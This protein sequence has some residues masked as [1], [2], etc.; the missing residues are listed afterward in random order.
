MKTYGIDLRNKVLAKKVGSKM[1]QSQRL[2]YSPVSSHILSVQAIPL[3]RLMLELRQ[4]QHNGVL[5]MLWANFGNAVESL[6]ANRMRSLLTSLGIIIGVAAV[7]GSLTLSQ[8]VNT[9]LANM[10]SSLGANTILIYPA[11]ARNGGVVQSTLVSTLTPRDAQDLQSVP[12]VVALSPFITTSDEVA[13]SNQNWNTQINGVSASYQQIGGWNLVEGTWF[14]AD[15]DARGNAVV[16]IGDTILQNL[17]DASGKDPLGQKIL[18]RNQVFRVVGVLAS[19]GQMLGG[20]PDD[21]VFIPFKTARIRLKNTTSLDQ[22]QVMVD[23]TNNVQQTQDAIARLLRG[24]HHI[25]RADGTTDDFNVFSFLQLLQQAQ[26]AI[27]I[28]AFVLIG[29]AVIA[30]VAG[31]I[32]IMNIMLVAVTERTREIGIRRALGARRGD[33]RNQFLIEA[34]VLC[35]VGGL[36]GLLLG[37]LLGRGLTQIPGATLPFVVTPITMIVPFVVSSAVAISFGLYPAIQ[38]SR[39][40]PIAAIRLE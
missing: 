37:L 27:Q 23:T 9:W 8:G 4:G 26:Q 31:G 20:S 14:S 36:I 21:V 39:L 15:D 7:I 5:T 28:F 35:L 19:K 6:W 30:L 33:I 18:I 34:L 11:V 13:Y 24:N 29:I 38:A 40:D 22:I 1:K 2:I 32:G 16:I 17:F 10:I 3:E 12:H 25:Q